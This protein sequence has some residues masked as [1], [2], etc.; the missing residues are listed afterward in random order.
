MI[1]AD[2]GRSC[3]QGRGSDSK[4]PPSSPSSSIQIPELS[5]SSVRAAYY[6]R[7]H[8]DKFQHTFCLHQP[9]WHP[10]YCFPNSVFTRHAP[11]ALHPASPHV[12]SRPQPD[13]F[14]KLYNQPW[15][16]GNQWAHSEE[17]MLLLYIPQ[18]FSSYRFN[19]PTDQ[20]Y[21]SSEHRLTLV[22]LGSS[23]FFS[24]RHWL[25]HRCTTTYWRNI[26]SQMRC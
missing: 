26:R 2:Q 3:C 21:I 11:Q 23:A 15:Q 12:P 24:A 1:T 14:K 17:G 19:T 13:D 5:P 22:S 25:A 9:T 18:S 7:A 10:A 6:H 20:F 8:Q 16:C 4:T